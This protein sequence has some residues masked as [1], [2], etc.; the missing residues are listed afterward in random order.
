MELPPLGE[1]ARPLVDVANFELPTAAPATEPPVIQ[2]PLTAKHPVESVMPLAKVED[3]VVDVIFNAVKVDVAPA[4]LSCPLTETSPENVPV[5]PESAEL[6]PDTVL[7]T[8]T[9]ES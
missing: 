2:I 5:V 7:V 9:L 4:A 8:T 3:A 1:T 6:P